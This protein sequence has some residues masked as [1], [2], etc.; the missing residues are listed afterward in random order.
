MT[1][2]TLE[3]RDG[4][5]AALL[6]TF[7]AHPITGCLSVQGPDGAKG[8]IHIAAGRLVHAETS[9][10]GGLSALAE[11]LSWRA[12][13]YSLDEADITVAHS[14]DLTLEQLLSGVAVP[15]APIQALPSL[16]ALLDEPIGVQVPSYGSEQFVPA[17]TDS[18]EPN[19]TLE[20]LEQADAELNAVW[21]KPFSTPRGFF[22][23]FAQVLASLHDA[24]SPQ[25]RAR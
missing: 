15:L 6:R 17:S 11:M 20:M 24:L 21:S 9:K 10:R 18:T 5:V 7:L 12:G 25:R 1:S 14:L 13:M 2:Q 8:R 3:L 23:W 4:V 22:G 19:E 16:E